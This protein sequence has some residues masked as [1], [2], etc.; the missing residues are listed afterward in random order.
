[1]KHFLHSYTKALRNLIILAF[2][3]AGIN[4]YGAAYYVNA[5]TGNNSNTGTSAGAP[6]LTIQKAINSAAAGDKIIIASGVYNKTVII[7][8]NITLD[9]DNANVTIKS[10]V[11]NT[12]MVKA[13]ITSNTTTGT[14]LITDSLELSN[15][16]VVI[17][18]TKPPDIKT[19]SGAKLVGGNKNSY[20][21]GGYW[22]GQTNNNSIIWNVGTGTDYRPIVASF[23]KSGT[24]E[25]FYYAK[26]I[27][28]A[29]SFSQSLPA[30]TRNI[31]KVHHYYLNT[32]ASNTVAYNFVIRF[33][34]DSINNDD[35]VYDYKNLQILN[36]NGSTAW[37]INNSAGTANRLGSISTTSITNLTGY[38]ILGNKLGSQYLGGTPYFGGT[39]SLGSNEVFGGITVVNTCEGDTIKFYS[40]SKSTGSTISSYIWNF[41]DGSPSQKGAYVWHIYKRSYPPQ[42]V[43]SYFVKLQ[44][45]NAVNIDTGY[46][47]IIIA[48][49]PRVPLNSSIWTQSIDLLPKIITSVCQGQTTRITDTYSP[50][51]GESIQQKIWTISNVIPTYMK[52]N[53]PGTAG[54][55]DSTKV[56]FKF[57][58]AGKYRIFI[59]RTN[60]YG[61]TATDSQDYIHHAKPDVSI[62]AIDQCWDANK[63]ISIKNNTADPSPD[64]MLKWSWDLGDG[65]KL[66]GQ[67]GPPI[68]NKNVYYKYAKAGPKLIKLIVVSDADCRD[69]FSKIINLFAKPN[70]Q[71]SVKQYCDTT[72]TFNNSS[73]SSPENI[74]NSI[75][76]WGDGS[77]P[78]TIFP[79]AQHIYSKP[80]LYKVT[81]DA[82]TSNNCTDTQ[83][84]WHRVVLKSNITIQPKNQNGKINDTA[85]FSVAS[86]D[87]TAKYRWQTDA[88]LG[89]QNL[90]NA[91]QY[92]GAYNDTLTVASLAKTN[93]KQLFRCI[94]NSGSCIDTSQ[95]A[96]LTV[97]NITGNYDVSK[98]NTLTILPNPVKSLLY[99][100]S[101][102]KTIG[103]SYEIYSNIGKSIVKGI[104]TAENTKINLENLSPGTYFLKTNVG[105]FKFV[106]E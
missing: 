48:N 57:P 95:T 8:K 69:S 34:Y 36:S 49:N 46:K 67:T 44:V 6:Y 106:K 24:Y 12:A 105:N 27:A 101:D 76:N 66:N 58:F 96:L 93:N 55:K 104:I 4:L 81:M 52:G 88:G 80:G 82:Q 30:T 97:L 16:L 74:K 39:N 3:S 23:T 63:F 9:I 7:T 50:P 68:L 71:F 14:L 86:S 83:T 64:K 10:L 32:S 85:T 19:K 92:N 103:S 5:T 13:T 26:V 90:S 51:S 25:E 78:D 43:Y 54:Y 59:T 62:D 38:Y 87:I 91:G 79:N 65:T 20:V 100:K 89:F 61:C 31:S 41:G 37:T 53:T 84:L 33:Y 99:V 15:G 40:K 18:G 35:H 56:T 60:Q 75:W 70:A 72:R 11:L 22:I 73:V 45:E 29:P 94:V 42:T 98:Q 102:S 21:D 2:F 17:T 47:S 77:L 1:M 28:G